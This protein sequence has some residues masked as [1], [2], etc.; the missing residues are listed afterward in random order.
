[1]KAPRV[2]GL[3][4]GAVLACVSV[5]VL[6]VAWHSFG[7]NDTVLEG[8]SSFYSVKAKNEEDAAAKAV[9]QYAI[10]N[11][12]VIQY[13][14][15]GN[16]VTVVAKNPEEAAKKAVEIVASDDIA[17]CAPPQSCPP[18]PAPAPAPAPSQ[19]I[20]PVQVNAVLEFPQNGS[21]AKPP[22]PCVPTGN[23]EQP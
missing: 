3:R 9:A 2:L 17:K 1:M 21:P 15:D 11:P 10:A 22:R 20:N 6:T 16:L 13:G 23:P 18:T 4:S 8:A 19:S 7:Q 5:L 14:R 12:P